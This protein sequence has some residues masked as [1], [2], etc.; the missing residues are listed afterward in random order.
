VFSRWWSPRA[1]LA[2]AL[3]LWSAC[4]ALALAAGPPLNGDEA[5]Y[6][7]LARGLDGTWIYRPIGLVAIAKLGM[8]FG[9]S[10][11]ALRLTCALTSPLLLVATF[12]VGRKLGRWPGAAAALTLAGT[13]TFVLRAPELLNDIP[14][15]SCLLAAI[16]LMVTELDRDRGPGYRLVAVAPLFAAAF[17]LRYGTA[18]VIAI[19]SAASIVMWSREVR[20]R[21]YPVVVTALVFAVLVAP[22]FV[23]SEHAT[24]SLTGILR[25]A[26]DASGRR[27][28]G[29]GLR[30][31]LSTGTLRFYGVLITPLMI[32]GLVSVFRPPPA[33]RRI[34]RFL[35][36]VAGGQVIAIG[37]VSHASTRFVFLAMV[38]FAILGIEYLLRLVQSPRWIAAGA[39]CLVLAAVVM[40]IAVVPLEHKIA[41]ELASTVA[42]ARAIHADAGEQPCTVVARTTPQLM[43]YSRCNGYKLDG[44]IVAVPLAR[45]RRWYVAD[46]PN[47]PI[48]ATAVAAHAGAAL[49]A[50]AVAGAWRLEVPAATPAR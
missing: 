49:V 46:A 21:P 18:P 9:G 3:V 43:W 10:D 22:F 12:M 2:I 36:M 42:A 37:L 26:A 25:V 33:A 35:A 24:G 5:S 32:I 19:I 6:S 34:A 15:T 48:D 13:H 4:V 16:A 50:L 20:A 29:Q 17:Y 28:L 14:S 44:P 38:L 31:Y 45:D 8:A 23:Y 7:L 11:T 41:R 40:T 47:R 27:Y 30:R 1:L 39:G